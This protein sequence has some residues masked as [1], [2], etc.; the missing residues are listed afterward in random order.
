[1]FG[2]KG[3]QAFIV[4][5]FL[6]IILNLKSLSSPSSCLKTLTFPSHYFIFTFRSSFVSP[7]LCRITS[8]FPLVL[9]SSF[10]IF[11]F[12]VPHLALLLKARIFNLKVYPNLRVRQLLYCFESSN[13]HLNLQSSGFTYFSFLSHFP[14]LRLLQ[15]FASVCFQI[16]DFFYFLLWICPLFSH[17]LQ[18]IKKN[19]LFSHFLQVMKINVSSSLDL[20]SAS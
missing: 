9:Y 1:M 16:S 18:V 11:P 7:Y 10:L 4:C 3:L 19:T 5:H 14:Y 13:L 8:S 17:F 12:T 2:N 15:I 20:F 6:P